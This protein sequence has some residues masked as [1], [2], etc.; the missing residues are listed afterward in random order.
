MKHARGRCCGDQGRKQPELAARDVATQY[1]IETNSP[2]LEG[3]LATQYALS[4]GYLGLRGTHEEMPA[5]ASPGFFV[6]GTYAPGPREKLIGIHSPD[7]ILAHPERIKPVHPLPR[8]NV[9]I[10]LHVHALA[11]LLD[12]RHVRPKQRIVS[13]FQPRLGLGRRSA[14]IRADRH[15]HIQ[16]HRA[17]L[18][19]DLIGLHDSQAL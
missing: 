17:L 14:R 16:D 12:R 8:E 11:R 9:R 10:R 4:N 19:L 13:L 18:V 2:A 15:N 1:W 6:A 3:R 5:W 7:H